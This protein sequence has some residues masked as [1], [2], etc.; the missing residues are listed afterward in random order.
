MYDARLERRSLP[1]T[2]WKKRG[3]MGREA[4]RMTVVIS[5]QL[6][7]SSALN[8]MGASYHIPPH[9]HLANDVS[10]VDDVRH[11]HAVDKANDT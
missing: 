4:A 10:G 6:S 5:A 2:S 7:N 11:L 3:R 8:T 1:V 9:G